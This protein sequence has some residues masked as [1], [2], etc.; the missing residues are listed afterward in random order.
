MVAPRHTHVTEYKLG[1]KSQ[2]ESDKHYQRGKLPPALRVHAA[3][4]FGPP[5]MQA[6]E[7]SEQSPADHNVV[8]VRHYEI[9]ITQ[10]HVHCQRRQ[11]QSCHTTNRKESN[12]AEG[13]KHRRLIRDRRLVKRR[14]PV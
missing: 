7:V 13:I 6:A 11:K 8:E 2:V 4:D 10:M 14:R 5:V 9:R 12:E 3:A 1:Q